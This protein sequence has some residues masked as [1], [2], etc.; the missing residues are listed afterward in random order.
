MMIHTKQNT[1]RPILTF[2]EGSS[3]DALP[4][5]LLLRLFAFALKLV[6]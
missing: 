4:N 1:H 2:L 5:R 6:A 3:A